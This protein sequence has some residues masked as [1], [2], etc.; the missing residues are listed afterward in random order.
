MCWW[1]L[2]RVD[3]QRLRR[4]PVSV[5]GLGRID[6]KWLEPLE[7]KDIILEMADDLCFGVPSGGVISG[8]VPSGSVD[9]GSEA[10]CAAA[11]RAKYVEMRRS[12][13]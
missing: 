10:E 1:L 8:S 9:S 11:W 6:D 13:N 3:H 5:V 7:M 2:L 12:V 4:R